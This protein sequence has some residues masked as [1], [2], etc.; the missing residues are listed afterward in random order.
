MALIWD[1]KVSEENR[2]CLVCNS[3]QI[4]NEMHFIFYIEQ[5]WLLKI[6]QNKNILPKL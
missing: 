2:L 1:T 5:K 6:K 3:D 4:E